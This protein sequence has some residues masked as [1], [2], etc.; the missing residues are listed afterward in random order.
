MP[1]QPWSYTPA[2]WLQAMA[3]AD[4]FVVIHSPS[5]DRVEA[6]TRDGA[7]AAVNQLLLD[8]GRM[9]VARAWVELDGRMV[10][11]AEGTYGGLQLLHG[12]ATAT[13]EEVTK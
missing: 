8:N 3:D 1:T 13:Y 12:V 11:V 2:E 4:T 7:I 9:G 6:A 5:G 10:P